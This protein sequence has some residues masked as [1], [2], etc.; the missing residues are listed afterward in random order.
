VRG[1]Y[2]TESFAA[3]QVMGPLLRGEA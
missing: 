2:E 1:A 3:H